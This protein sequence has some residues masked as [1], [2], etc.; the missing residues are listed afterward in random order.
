VD[1]WP[2]VPVNADGLAGAHGGVR[3]D[4]RGVAVAGDV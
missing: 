3:G 2:S 1:A 4:G